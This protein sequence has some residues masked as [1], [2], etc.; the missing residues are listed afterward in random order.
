MKEEYTLTMSENEVE[1]YGNMT[2]NHFF[3]LLNFLDLQGFVDIQIDHDDGLCLFKDRSKDRQKELNN[4]EIFFE[5]QYELAKREKEGLEKE[6]VEQATKINTLRE[7]IREKEQGL[8]HEQQ[9]MLAQQKLHN[10]QK[11]EIIKKLFE[12]SEAQKIIEGTNA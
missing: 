9:T 5:S 4:R 1:I 6:N 11:E 8:T 12:N 7:I 10:K 2:L 3:E